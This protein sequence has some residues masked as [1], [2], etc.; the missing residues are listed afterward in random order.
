MKLATWNI[1][2]VR[3]RI[4]NIVRFINKE[5]IDVLCLQETKTIDEFFPLDSFSSSSPLI[6]SPIL[7]V[8]RDC[9]TI[10]R[11]LQKIA[12]LTKVTRGVRER[13]HPQRPLPTREGTARER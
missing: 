4:D 8:I 10:L 13:E 3:L 5:K 11:Q 7:L 1:N 12:R 6:L 2:S 9:C